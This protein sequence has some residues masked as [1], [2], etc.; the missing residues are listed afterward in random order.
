MFLLD[1]HFR[2]LGEGSPKTRER[3]RYPTLWNRHLGKQAVDDS[4][5]LESF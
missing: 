2:Y 3:E 1:V 4:S 5:Y